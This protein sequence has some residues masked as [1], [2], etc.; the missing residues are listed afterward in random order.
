VIILRCHILGFGK[1][2]NRVL[3]FQNGLNLVYAANEG[4]KSTLQRFLV[5]LLYGQM[6]SDLKVQRRLDP[7][8]DQYKPWHAEEY[9]GVLWCRLS[10]GR[11][12][13]I[14]RF[15]GRDE[16]RIEIR[17]ASGEDITRQ[18]EQQRNGEV[19]FARTHF[20]MPKELFESVG[21]IREN[22]AAEIQGYETIRDRIANLAQSGDEELSI[23]K[24]LAK[25]QEKLDEIGSD[26][27]PTRPYKQTMDLV[28][29]LRNERQA[30][31][32][33]RAQFQNW[34]EE[35]N[36]GAEEIAKL[37]RELARVQ[38]ALLA[39]RR[40]EV[41]DRIHSLEEI[42]AELSSLRSEIDSLG[43]RADFP[44]ND[45]EELNH[46]VGASESTARHLN[47][48]RAE[49]DA[50]LEELRRAE[51]QKQEL[52]AYASFAQGTEAEKIT[53]WFVSYLSL[54]L[55]KDGI[56]KTLSRLSEE[57]AAL[58]KRLK[59]LN[60]SLLDPQNNWERLARE[61]AEDEQVSSQNCTTVTG[62]LAIERGRLA[63][64]SRTAKNRKILARVLLALA[65]VIPASLL[66]TGLDR[67]LLIALGLLSAFA[68]LGITMLFAASKS[69]K[70]QRTIED[71][72]KAL[73]EELVSLR[74]EG[75]QK[76][77]SLNEAV[78][79]SGFQRLDD[80]LSA[81]RRCDQDRQKLADLHASFA[82]AEQQ[83]ERAQTQIADIFDRLKEG[84]AKAGL[85]CSPGNLKFQID[86]LRSNLRRY[87]ELD[88]H[89]AA[90]LQ[91]T[92]SLKSRDAELSD[93]FERKRSR[94]QSLLDQA[95]VESPEK[96]REEC[97]KRQRLLEL[98]EKESSR[99]REFSR[100][101][102]DRTLDRW[103]DHLRELFEQKSPEYVAEPSAVE[104]GEEPRNPE[105][106]LPYLPTIT[107]AEEQERRIIAQLA[108]AREEHA[109][110]VERV[111]QAF[112]GF[113][114]AYEIE[115]D[116]A[117]AERN[118]AELEKNRLALDTAFDTLK[119]LSRQQQ[120]VLA[121]QLNAAVEQRFLRL[122]AGRYEEV[123]IDPD[124]QVWVRET[125]TTELRL[126]EHLSRGTQDQL[127]FAMRFGILDLVSNAEEPC[128]GFLD[129]PFAAY[130]HPR[131]RQAFEV[132]SEE[133][134]R[135]QVILFTCRDDLLTLAMEHGANIIELEE[136]ES[137]GPDQKQL[138]STPSFTG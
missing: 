22:R 83:R 54:S 101:A 43:A 119:K 89:Y 125:N 27:A 58:E 93:E 133:V 14:H 18:Y 71:A 50:A 76:R 136:T 75:S 13:G 102:G 78:K 107:E 66:L 51:S 6:R 4:G 36:R 123:K 25:I 137:R 19:L 62:R 39:A 103:Q 55:H 33:R 69:E 85:S 30:L 86:L 23:R 92:D 15:F 121:P 113:R 40:R 94:I 41:A 47:E 128:P 61:A 67:P 97:A 2:K 31:E 79:N 38:T 81:A 108:G 53:E 34:V 56:Q 88:A 52:E 59:E 115:E 87:R 42:H 5:A 77:K 24:S 124:F 20:G 118:L 26:R 10:D 138:T 126:A 72:V 130:D 122:C 95:Q 112:R 48:I 12:L 7:W 120:E 1:F 64:V 110:A 44:A 117:L 46:L 29:N 16:T 37:G 134:K 114:P 3:D 109:R 60:P 84:L 21:I 11:E 8:V 17:T 91:K 32:E 96:F 63:A 35:R 100:L 104:A 99:T 57:A 70:E 106:Y 82:E 45:L 98:T 132:L 105:P 28:Q 74:A 73:E 65:V 80:F 129:E 90:I 127:Y 116:L 111:K 9:G 68:V 135:R 49:K 131:L